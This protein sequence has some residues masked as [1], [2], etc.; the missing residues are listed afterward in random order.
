M[1]KNLQRD[2]KE[3]SRT[4]SFHLGKPAWESSELISVW[5]LVMAFF[6]TSYILTNSRASIVSWAC[7]N[8]LKEEEEFNARELTVFASACGSRLDQSKKED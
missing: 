6:Y 5:E 7:E 8:D 1:L 3:W 2:L 4:D